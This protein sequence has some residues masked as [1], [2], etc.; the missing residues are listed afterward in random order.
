MRQRSNLNAVSRTDRS[1][2]LPHRTLAEFV[3]AEIRRRGV[4]VGALKPTAACPHM[5]TKDAFGAVWSSRNQRHSVCKR[6]VE[7]RPLRGRTS[8]LRL[9]YQE[10]RYIILYPEELACSCVGLRQLTSLAGALWML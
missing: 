10:Q 1:S 4:R 5:A 3:E 9:P 8:S 6:A 2:A 7:L